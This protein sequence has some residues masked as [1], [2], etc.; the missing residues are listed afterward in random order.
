M[1]VQNIRTG[2]RKRRQLRIRRKVT[3][4][5]ERPR[6]SIFRSHKNIYAQ[7]IN[8]L[9][10]KTLLGVSTLSETIKEKVKYGG[11]VKAAEVLGEFLAQE[12]K[13]LKIEKIVFDR[14]GY[15]YH[16]RVKALA[17]AARTGGLVF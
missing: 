1:M 7:L 17:D 4:T 9:D 10:G 5:L 16:G 14:S 2:Q 6:L 11:N 13:Q 15:K 12:A 3:G 8:D